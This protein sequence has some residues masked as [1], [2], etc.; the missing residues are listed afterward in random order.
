MGGIINFTNI[1]IAFFLFYLLFVVKNFY[2]IFNPPECSSKWDDNCLGA[3]ENW[4]KF[5]R[6]NIELK[7]KIITI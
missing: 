4:Q 1:T 2:D 3:I 7:N 6:V 5:Y